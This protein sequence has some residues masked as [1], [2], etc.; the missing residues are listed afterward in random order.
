MEMINATGRRKEAVARVYIKPGSGNIT[1]NGRD[2][3]SYFTVEHVQIKVREALTEVQVQNIYDVNVNVVGGG[4]KGQ[5]EA[6]RL[7]ISRALT[8]I[9]AEFRSP[10]K[11]KKFLTRDPRAVERK[12]YGQPKARRRFQFSKR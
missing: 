5:A 6:V 11:A 2:Y 8:E 4:I 12:K 1:V 10:L 7:G 3:K 9:N